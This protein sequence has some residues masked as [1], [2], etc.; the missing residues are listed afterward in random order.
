MKNKSYECYINKKDYRNIFVKKIYNS[1]NDIKLLTKTEN[2]YIMEYNSFTELRDSI[3]KS[4][5]EIKTANNPCG[6]IALTIEN[7]TQVCFFEYKN[8]LVTTKLNGS[9]YGFISFDLEDNT[10]EDSIVQY[11][12]PTIENLTEIIKTHTGISGC[13]IDKRFRTH[14]DKF[15]A[16]S[17]YSYKNKL[18][19]LYPLIVAKEDLDKSSCL[20]ITDQL[21]NVFKDFHDN[22]KTYHKHTI[23]NEDETFYYIKFPNQENELNFIDRHFFC[24][25]IVVQYI[26]QNKI[27]PAINILSLFEKKYDENDLFDKGPTYYRKGR[28]KGKGKPRTK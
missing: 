9:T 26:Y 17:Y 12:S 11:K 13:K 27:I 22:G 4:K 8:E 5:D 24:F 15:N 21:F 1:K 20:Y 2:Y 18:F 19:Y 28:G 23:I 10:A 6:L 16:V 3:N 25:L 7:S 14:E